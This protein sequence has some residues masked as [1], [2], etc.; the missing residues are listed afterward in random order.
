MCFPAG[1]GII[2]LRVWLKAPMYDKQEDIRK[3]NIGEYDPLN[4]DLEGNDKAP[5]EEAGK[6]EEVTND[7]LKGK[8][9]DADPVFEQP[10]R[11]LP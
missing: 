9:V 8:K 2:I 11:Q 10:I 3:K 6:G 5:G 1:F 4:K 7:D